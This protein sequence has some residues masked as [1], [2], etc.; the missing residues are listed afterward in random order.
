MA[1]GDR[2]DLRQLVVDFGVVPL[3]LDDQQRLDVGIARPGEGLAGADA[4]AVHEFNGD[5][6]DARLD[7][8]GDAGA[9]DLVAV[10]PHQDRPRAFRLGQNAQRRFR[11]HAELTFGT[12][13]DAE[14]VQP[15]RV[16]R[17]AAD[18][19][20]FPIHRHQ[21]DAQKVVRRHP[22]FQAMR[23][24]GVHTNIPGDGAGEL[25]RRVGGVEK[26]VRFHRAGDGKIGHAGLHADETIF[27]VHLKHLSEP[28]DAENDAVRRRQRS[29]GK[30]SARSARHHRD[31]QFGADFQNGGDF[32][33]RSWQ[34][35]GQRRALICRQSVA[36]VHSDLFRR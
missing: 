16:E 31:A 28:R 33:G 12:A 14:K 9:C 1:F 19:H 15:R 32:F 21:R 8:V 25:A 17:G 29:A 23:P 2:L 3:D 10:K 36:F 22:V 35:G 7:D 20:H 27:V 24:T 26:P 18:L 30:R 6:Q 11:H 13:D 34:H 4:G 5:G